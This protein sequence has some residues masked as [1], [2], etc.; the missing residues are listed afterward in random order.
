MN[1]KTIIKNEADKLSVNLD[2]S[3]EELSSI[4]FHKVLNMPYFENT[5]KF[6][7]L[8]ENEFDEI[9]VG[10][11]ELN[12]IKYT[13]SHKVEKTCIDFSKEKGN[14]Y[15]SESLVTPYQN[16]EE[17]DLLI[18]YKQIVENSHNIKSLIEALEKR[19]E[20]DS[21]FYEKATAFLPNDFYDKKSLYALE[22][23]LLKA[24]N[25]EEIEKLEEITKKSYYRSP[26]GFDALFVRD[27]FS[28]ELNAL[29]KLDNND[30]QERVTNLD[31]RT[32]FIS[33]EREVMNLDNWN[34]L[35]KNEKEKIWKNIEKNETLYNKTVIKYLLENDNAQDKIYALIDAG[36]Y[37]ICKENTL[38]EINNILKNPSIDTLTLPYKNEVNSI[39]EKVLDSYP[40]LIENKNNVKFTMFEDNSIDHNVEKKLSRFLKTK[41]NLSIYNN[42]IDWE[43]AVKGLN[44]V[45]S[46]ND[47][48]HNDFINIYM[49]NEIEIF[50]YC[51][52]NRYQE[53]KAKGLD[54]L[55][56][57]D[58]KI[59]DSNLTTD[60]LI[61]QPINKLLEI[62]K[63]E[64]RIM[65]YD[66]F[67][68]PNKEEKL[69]IQYIENLKKERNDII[70]FNVG[71]K[72]GNKDKIEYELQVKM[73]E[74]EMFGATYGKEI[75]F[76]N[77]LKM[78][79]K[80]SNIINSEKIN[81]IIIHYETIDRFD[82]KKK[83][84]FLNYLFNSIIQEKNIKIRNNKI[85]V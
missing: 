34:S 22:R 49:S 85:K 74:E 26:N 11:K 35:E 79:E 50:G 61:E 46:V 25:S 47:D 73:F 21:I 53:R 83:D 64:N 13:F 84:E 80:I 8:G 40:I 77:I 54:S 30:L 56:L 3:S 2:I 24:T 39:V 75:E 65:T 23:N 41:D 19:S 32:L 62:A 38:N 31:L 48:L 29:I 44:V 52:G 55:M 20:K 63:N 72:E 68:Q 71:Y 51:R 17:R 76:K 28:Y 67:N 58:I 15:S 42:I 6:I 37:A 69:A 60:R 45:S 33:I 59:K 82:H 43:Y 70:F 5:Y 18:E 9:S 66:F 78:N 16:Q 10:H 1:I 81:E 27:L 4:A 36:Y 7:Q 57:Y 14:R 12:N